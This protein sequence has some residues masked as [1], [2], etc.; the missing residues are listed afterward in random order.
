MIIRW[1][2]HSSFMLASSDGKLIVTDP[3]DESVGCSFPTLEP[4]A[5]TVSHQHHDHN[6]VSRFEN[7][8]SVFA[9]PQSAEEILP[10][11]TLAGFK[12]YHDA[13]SGA[14]RGENTVFLITMDDVRILHLGD[15]GH[16]LDED[17]IAE[18]GR[19]DVLLI[20]VGG[21]YT[22]DAEAAAKLT[23]RLSPS[24]AIPMHYR[25]E[26]TA[27]WQIDDEKRYLELMGYTDAQRVEALRVMPDDCGS[28]PDCALFVPAFGFT[29]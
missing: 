9:E 17:T 15:L 10:E 20:P 7:S 19:V 6:A 24:V 25:N 26:S 28:Q 23:K 29:K 4:D 16:A 13:E 21:N 14:K 1:L 18:I 5:V 8:P 27:D 11:I 22:I 2:G 3:F 12:T